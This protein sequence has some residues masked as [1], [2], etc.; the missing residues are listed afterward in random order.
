MTPQDGLVKGMVRSAV[1][2]LYQ[3]YEGWFGPLLPLPRQAPASVGIRTVDYQ[4]GVNLDY[5]PRG[6]SDITFQQLRNMADAYYLV[7]SVIETRKDQIKKVQWRFGL[8]VT[9][10]D[11]PG[12][13]RKKSQ[14]DPRVQKIETFFKFPDGFHDWET[15]L[16]MWIEDVLVTDAPAFRIDKNR[17]GDVTAL[18]QVTGETIHPLRA[19]DGTVPKAPEA[20]YQQILKGMVASNLTTEELLYWPR[21]PRVNKLYGFSPIEQI[22]L[23]LNMGLRKAISQINYFTDGN[24]PD[25]ICMVP[26]SW[27]AEQIKQF[28]AWFDSALQGNLAKRRMVNF[29]PG[30]GDKAGNKANLIFPKEMNLKDDMDEYIARA[31]CF[32]FSLPPTAFVRQQN[33]A[34]AQTAQQTALQEGLEPLKNYVKNRINFAIQSPTVHNQPDIEIS[35]DEDAEPDQLKQAQID[36]IY[37]SFGKVSVD[38]LRDRDGQDKIGVGPGVLL[39]TG[40][41]PFKD[42]QAMAPPPP[43][44]AGGPGGPDAQGAPAWAP[45]KK[46]VQ[47]LIDS[48]V[49]DIEKS[50][51]KKKALTIS[52]AKLPEKATK[53]TNG[54]ALS[55]T[56]FLQQQ[57]K[58]I[59]TTVADSYGEITKTDED[60]ADRVLHDLE[61]DWA[62]L[63]GSVGDSLSETARESAR[64]TLL[65]VGVSDDAI[66]G[67]VNQDALDFATARAAE[68]VGKKIVNGELVDNPNA[69]WAITDTTRQELRTI[70][71]NAFEE[72]M[73]P[74]QL[75][76]A[77]RDSFQFSAARAEMI[78]RT[79]MASAHIQGSL[80]AATRSGVVVGKRSLLSSEHDVDDECDD[81]AE[82]GEIE[83]TGLFP[84]GHAGPPFHPSCVCGMNL[85]YEKGDN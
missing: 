71:A 17:G 85:V 26:D 49:A 11:A 66:F 52:I 81:N 14:N 27:G 23:I 6:S 69:H 48:L 20:A 82:A 60:Q 76:T 47:K 65:E 55:L 31:V 29:M 44:F 7:R 72:G 3:R 80:V 67:L 12:S 35:A 61:L 37:V 28:Q 54:L 10:G 15:W 40:F 24:I 45:K 84:S 58:K 57:G 64:D 59:A 18:V 22:I 5:I 9:P 8:K 19:P 30:G 50:N 1:Q 51:L 53:R 74:A 56:R 73:T 79:E 38:E 33:R 32:A 43:A 46:P 42:G 78:A 39:P 77:V 4:A 62:A 36:K 70:I 2:N 21:N 63:V 34:T 75:E 68:L 41:F 16:G 25:A 83:L 13:I